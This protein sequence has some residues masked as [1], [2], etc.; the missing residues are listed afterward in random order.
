MTSRT[1]Q[2]IHNVAD[3]HRFIQLGVTTESEILEFKKDVSAWK[4][5]PS[6]KDKSKLEFARDVAQFANANGGCIVFGIEESA[7]RADGRRVAG[8]IHTVDDVD[9]KHQWLSQAIRNHLVPS[10]ASVQFKSLVINEGTLL[11]LNIPP[12]STTVLVWDGESKTMECVVRRGSHK[13]HL[14]PSEMILHMADTGRAAR[15]KLQQLHEKAT[16]HQANRTVVLSSGVWEL[17]YAEKVVK[18]GT[19]LRK[20]RIPQRIPCNLQIALGNL[21]ENEFELRCGGTD[22]VSVPYGLVREVWQT[23]D[24]KIGIALSAK[25]VREERMLFVET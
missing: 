7:P 17:V 5:A 11:T 10:T 2:F 19:S 6:A 4:G 21:A 9:A 16:N 12:H 14:N 25:I 22:C 15:I 20:V 8:A 23:A 18:D 1:P 24:G 3:F 13:V